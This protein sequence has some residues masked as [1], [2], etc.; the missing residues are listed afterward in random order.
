MRTVYAPFVPAVTSEFGNEVEFVVDDNLSKERVLLDD[1]DN[2]TS[3]QSVIDY[4]KSN[5][6]KTFLVGF[7]IFDNKTKFG[8]SNIVKFDPQKAV[9]GENGTIQGGLIG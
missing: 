7:R 1:D 9:Y 4:M 2:I 5:Q 8:L 3:G 6:N